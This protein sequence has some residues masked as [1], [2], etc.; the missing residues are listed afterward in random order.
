M[1]IGATAISLIA[2]IL[3]QDNVVFAHK[4]CSNKKHSSCHI[5]DFKLWWV[6]ASI[7][8]NL[9]N[10]PGGVRVWSSPGMSGP[11]GEG[12]LC[13]QVSMLKDFTEVINLSCFRIFAGNAVSQGEF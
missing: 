12:K 8:G 7:F 11:S 13:N 1:V 4:R 3:Q 6:G 9:A 10:S 2:F 5:Q